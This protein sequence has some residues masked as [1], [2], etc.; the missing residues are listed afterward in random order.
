MK[1]SVHHDHSKWAV[2]SLKTEEN[3]FGFY[4]K[5]L[6]FKVDDNVKIG[7]LGDINRQEDQYRRGGGTVC[8]LSN[9]NLWEQYY[10]LVNDFESC[11]K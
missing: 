4:L 8:F 11:K 3:F 7:C 6:G 5:K 10:N 9:E 2:T 1:F